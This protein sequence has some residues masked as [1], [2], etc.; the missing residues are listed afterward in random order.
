MNRPFPSCFEPHYDTEAKRKVIMKIRA[1]SFATVFVFFWKMVH[2]RNERNI[3][4]FILPPIAECRTEWKEYGLLGID[5]IVIRVLLG[6]FWREILRG[7]GHSSSQVTSAI[8]IPFPDLG[9]FFSKRKFRV[10]CYS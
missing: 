2:F 4:P 3:I 6:N 7:R 10:F 8:G 9:A 5:R 1:R